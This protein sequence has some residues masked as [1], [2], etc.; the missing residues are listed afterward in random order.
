MAIAKINGAGN[1]YVGLESG[2]NDTGEYIV[3]HQYLPDNAD[4]AECLGGYEFFD[5]DEALDFIDDFDDWADNDV[6]VD[7]FL[8][9]SLN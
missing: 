1:E 3:L 9:D 8:N 2:I 7:V 5:L 6:E 4:S